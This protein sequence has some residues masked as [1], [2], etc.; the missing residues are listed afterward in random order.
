MKKFLFLCFLAP[1]AQAQTLRLGTLP[2]GGTAEFRKAGTEWG[3]FLNTA[4]QNAARQQ[5][6]IQV[7]LWRDSTDHPTRSAGYQSV[8][9]SGTN[10]MAKGTLTDG[11]IRFD[12]TDT[13][14]LD[15][16]VL[17]LSRSL[18]AHVAAD[19]RVPYTG[20]L[21]AFTLELARPQAR[22]QVEVF[23][24]GM[25]YGGTDRLTAVAIGG[26]DFQQYLRIR[27]DR[28]PA[29]LMG[30]RF[31]DG[32]TL[33]VLDAAPDGRTSRADADDIQVKTLVDSAVHVGAI[34]ADF[35]AGKTQL[36]FWLPG[37]E[38]EVTYTGNAY[39]GGQRH[40]WRRR[41]HPLRDRAT[42]QYEIRYQVGAARTFPDFYTAA[43]RWAW[44]T[45]RPRLT[46]HDLDAVRQALVRQL[47][48]EIVR[49][50]SGLVGISNWMQAPA[51]VPFQRDN[52][53]IMG[54]TGKAIEAAEH[55]L[56]DQRLHPAAWPDSVRQNA[57]EL[58]DT[59]TQK[60]SLAPPQGEG[61]DLRTGA[62]SQALFVQRVEEVF[63]RSFTD[64]LKAL[65][66]AYRREK[67]AGVTHAHWL[68]WAQSFADW[69]LPQ[70]A[71]AGG[72]PRTWSFG[73]PTVTVGDASPAA[74]YTAVPL[75]VL[76]SEETGQ[77][78]Y[79]DAALRAAE[80]CWRSQTNGVFSGGTIDNPDVIDKEAGTLSLEAYLALYDATK[81]RKWLDRAG[82]AA[83]FAETWIF[84]WDIPMA[85][86]A[87]PARLHWKPGVPTTG[88]QL[89][90]TGHSLTDNY[91]AFDVDEYAR[92][93]RL[94]GDAHY[95]D[96]ARLLLH[97]TKNMIALPD[98]PFDLRAPG[99]S[100]EHFSFA[101]WR[102]YGL[103]RGWL[104]WVTT[105]H[106]NGMLGLEESDPKLYE[107]L[108]KP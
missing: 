88:A 62:F 15:G 58:I 14:A 43:W 89:I 67:A 51:G 1:L 72:F 12:V 18:T 20:F 13:W 39:P 94:T 16:G 49:Y 63:L 46:P 104:P 61:F 19:A 101:P 44:Q 52:K 82:A 56:L 103:H 59:F 71:A 83:R 54:F 55:V 93:Y 96:V 48:T 64:D 33:S 6:P 9:K 108:A 80:Y 22:R 57:I 25:I 68:R 78:R 41:Y 42:Q 2:G 100:Q 76:L 87:D 29:P 5:K 107:E 10:F 7:E 50:P 27:E 26:A 28:L 21:S 95:R 3:I 23:A 84:L 35:I 75:L 40:Q 60:L 77:R 81:D 92:L 74:S 53:G 31:A 47:T 69:L 91:M 36:G 90:S 98:R 102:G 106:L 4:G 24:P 17:R 66:R 11:P 73:K 34:G 8:T 45:L 85:A 99:W 37:I 32:R 97:N 86:D 79:L 105:A 30:L 38:G 65:L 70:Q